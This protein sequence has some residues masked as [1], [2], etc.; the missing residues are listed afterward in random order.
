MEASFNEEYNQRSLKI[1]VLSVEAFWNLLLRFLEA[2]CTR[3]VFLLSQQSGIK[4]TEATKIIR[5]NLYD[6]PA[7]KILFGRLG[8]P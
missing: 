4:A 3:L 2:Y 6:V 7:E 1:I 8:S 5:N